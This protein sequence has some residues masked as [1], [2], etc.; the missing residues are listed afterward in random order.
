MTKFDKHLQKMLELGIITDIAKFQEYF[1][2]NGLLM[3]INKIRVNDRYGNYDWN[4][5]NIYH[6]CTCSEPTNQLF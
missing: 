6:C 4:D 2:T 3:N 5:K 1:E